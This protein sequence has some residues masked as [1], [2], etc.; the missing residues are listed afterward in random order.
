MAEARGEPAP[1]L[2][3]EQA[4][5]ASAF[6]KGWA[7]IVSE[8]GVTPE[9]WAKRVV[10]VTDEQEMA[11][12]PAGDF[13][14]GDNGAYNPSDRPI[15]PVRLTKKYY[16]DVTEITR[17]Q[18]KQFAAAVGRPEP[19][20]PAGELR[21]PQCD[22]TFDDI[23]AYAAWAGARLPTEAEWER[24]ARGGHDDW[25]YPWEGGD[26]WHARNAS[27]P[28]FGKRG[29][30]SVGSFHPN[31]FGLYDMAG[32]AAEVCAG[33]LEPYPEKGAVQID[34]YLNVPVREHVVRGGGFAAD[35]V[36]ATKRGGWQGAAYK[37]IGFRLV[38]TA[39]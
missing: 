5:R 9:G 31:P 27:R 7:T 26:D 28:G 39:E 33:A 29:L 1:T 14:M 16:M 30:M 21:L 32:N 11:L 10:R 4:R 2:T 24:A 36:S 19:V 12:I 20:V 15:H 37:S 6:V 17:G 38:R 23:E 34:P 22:V 8:G 18:W 25:F 35:D 3:E 13:L